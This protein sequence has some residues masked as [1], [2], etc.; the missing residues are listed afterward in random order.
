V[1]DS[2]DARAV[3]AFA[4][5]EARL[6]GDD[7][8][9]V[10]A[11]VS[12]VRKQLAGRSAVTEGASSRLFVADDGRA[13]CSAWVAPRWQEAN[14]ADTGFVG[15][16]ALA[17]GA[18]TSAGEVLSAAE[19]WLRGE[20]ATRVLAPVEGVPILGVGARVR[21]F[22][23]DPCFPFRWQ[24]PRVAELLRTSG[25]EDFCPHHLYTVDFGT[26]EFAAASARAL[27]HA[28]ATVRPFDLENWRADLE[29]FRGVFNAGFAGE[30]EFQRYTAEEFAEVWG[31]MKPLLG[32]DWWLLA[33]VDGEPAG[34]CMSMPDW[35]KLW[36]SLKGKMGP[37]QVARLV[38]GAKRFER[39]GILAICLP[40][41]FRGRGIAALMVATAYRNYAAAGLERGVYYMVDDDNAHSRRLVES[42]GGTSTIDYVSF[43]KAL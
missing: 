2:A 41:E 28:S 16:V 40:P 37:I 14:D 18:E 25:Y 39:M 9:F 32:P 3:K 24:P 23:E 6:H 15:H 4:K 33:E 13:R 26:E 20:G 36:R 42:F 34:L 21:A 8:R 30:W 5:L 19:E 12:D 27:D 7:P 10:A 22:D 38:R 29:V 17:E 11:T 31:A 35:T 43:A 1:I